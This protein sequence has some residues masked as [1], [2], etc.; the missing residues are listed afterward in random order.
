MCHAIALSQRK[1]KWPRSGSLKLW[2]ERYLDS[3]EQ[4]AQPSQSAI[5]AGVRLRQLAE[6]GF[7]AQALKRLERLLALLEP[8]DVDA[9]VRLSLVGSEICLEIPNLKRAD[10]YL[11]AIEARLPEAR[12]N[13][14]KLLTRFLESFRILNGLADEV[15]GTDAQSRLGKYRHQYRLSVLDGD[16]SSELAAVRRATRLIPEVDD[17]ILERGLILSA[18]KA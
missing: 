9:F 6:C 5:S 12:P 2:L 1:T 14:R 10:K 7:E 13:K 8:T 15:S 3:C 4:L 16:Q 11:A 18:I 17:F